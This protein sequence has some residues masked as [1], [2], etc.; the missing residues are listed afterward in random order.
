MPNVSRASPLVAK[1]VVDDPDVATLYRIHGRTVMRWAARL[2]G[3]GIDLDD[4]VQDV[5]LVASRRLTGASFAAEGG[6]GG[7]AADDDAGHVEGRAKVTTWL[8]RTTE[9]V[10]RSARR[11]QRLR[12]WLSLSRDDAASGIATSRPGPGE[13]LERQREVRDVYRVLDRLPERERRV[14]ILFELEALSTKEIAALNG[15]KVGTVRV[16]LFR[17]RAR[18][19]EEHRR[20]FKAEAGSE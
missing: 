5:F 13:D 6:D 18:F 8:F 19:L 2:G 16:W 7:P 15:I 9:R 4:V 3:P 10:V 14:L 1:V 11:K 12:R 20:L 17:A